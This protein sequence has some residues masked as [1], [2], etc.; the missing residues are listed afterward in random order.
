MKETLREEK[1]PLADA[2]QENTLAEEEQ[3]VA[4][5][6][7]DDQNKAESPAA[8][9]NPQVN[10]LPEEKAEIQP[11]EN[12]SEAGQTPAEDKEEIFEETKTENDKTDENQETPPVDNEEKEPEGN[13]QN[14]EEVVPDT[15]S[16]DITE[17]AIAWLEEQIKTPGTVAYDYFV[18]RAKGTSLDSNGYNFA[19]AVNEALREALDL[20]AGA[21]FSWR[22]WKGS[23]TEGYSIFWTNSD[24]QNMQAKDSIDRVTR[25]NTASDETVE[26]TSMV[27]SRVVEGKTIHI[28]SGADFKAAV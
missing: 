5:Q 7:Q 2:P 24:I 13:G 26:G 12:A 6:I 1:L 16:E 15:E 21:T 17:R 20:D 10:V 28:I 11:E 8:V 14:D 18:L 22:I 19:P 3:E 9:I 25:Y 4:P 23:N 27:D